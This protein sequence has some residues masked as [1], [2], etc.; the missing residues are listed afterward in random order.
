MLMSRKGSIN[1]GFGFKFSIILVFFIL[2]CSVITAFVV[3]NRMAAE[4]KQAEIERIV[5]EQAISTKSMAMMFFVVETP[6]RGAMGVDLL[7]VDLLAPG[8]RTLGGVKCF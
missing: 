2:L 7:S 8:A 3:T 6:K 4:R 5:R 1:R